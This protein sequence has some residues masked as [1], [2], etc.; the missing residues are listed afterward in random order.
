MYDTD[1]RGP[2]MLLGCMLV[3]F[4]VVACGLFAVVSSD[5]VRNR[6]AALPRY[7]ETTYN[8]LRPKPALP[9]PPPISGVDATTLLQNPAGNTD[10]PAYT[11]DILN[12]A[13][14]AADEAAVVQLVENSVVS[15]IAPIA[16]AV[17]LPGIRHEW[18]TWNNCGP[19]TVAMNLSF[20]SHPGTQV[21]AAQ[22]LKPNADDK[23]VNPDELV[24]YATLQGYQ[25]FVGV[26]GTTEQLKQFLSNGLPVMVEFWTERDDAGG[27]GHYRLFSGFDAASN[28]FIAQD[29]LQGANLRVPVDAFDA[30]WRVFNR[31]YM[32]V[33]PAEKLPL[34]F[35]I[36]G[37]S[38]IEPLKY[39]QA[40]GVAQA[41]AQNNPADPFAWFNIGTNYA[42][43]GDTER[44]AAAFD[45]ARRL[46]LPYRML[47]YQFDIFAVYLAQGRTQ[48]LID[49]AGAVLDATGGLEELYYYRGLAYRAQGDTEAARADFE[50][51]LEYNPRFEPA[52]LELGGG[53]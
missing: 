21:E 5:S 49:L 45:E 44:A 10:T 2:A 36:A 25:G 37:K 28:Q 18:Q 53:N 8:K 35:T 50:A 13:E 34:A 41:E 22:F 46:G 23:N 15:E 42:R 30:D 32:L 47:W 20:Y 27:M 3:I 9:T 52:R 26:G 24:A 6:L 39:Q 11:D 43:L 16:P 51:A 14:A 40:L 12:S 38:A 29:S 1:R 48:E 7:A 19:S 33:F 17:A 31:T 4:V